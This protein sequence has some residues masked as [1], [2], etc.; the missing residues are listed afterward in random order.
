MDNNAILMHQTFRPLTMPTKFPITARQTLLHFTDRDPDDSQRANSPECPCNSQWKIEISYVS[1]DIKFLQSLIK[2]IPSEWR[3]TLI[4]GHKVGFRRH[5]DFSDRLWQWWLLKLITTSSGSGWW[6]R[7]SRSKVNL[8]ATFFWKLT[9]L[10]WGRSRSIWKVMED[11]LLSQHK[12]AFQ[13]T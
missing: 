13:A 3:V 10:R 11:P 4:S 7:Q 6:R 1:Y 8:R 5:R 2:R 9:N 12:Q